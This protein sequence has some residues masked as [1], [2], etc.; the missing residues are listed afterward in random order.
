MSRLLP[1]D[2]PMS[3]LLTN[4]FAFLKRAIERGTSTY[5]PGV[6]VTTLVFIGLAKLAYLLD[7]PEFPF[8][9]I[10]CLTGYVFGMPIGMAASPYKDEGS[11]FK[12]L[13]GYL[14]TFVTGLMA[15]KVSAL[16]FGKTFFAD[17]IT[18]GRTM[19]FLAFLVLAVVQ[20][21]MFRRYSD[22]RRLHEAY[23]ASRAKGK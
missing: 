22:R 15:A 20:T 2:P 11:H 5:I 17:R 14:V 16:D 7:P 23:T 6:I 19:L 10:L 21:F 4:V 8:T 18:S 13:A 1:N 9:G 12:T 3:R